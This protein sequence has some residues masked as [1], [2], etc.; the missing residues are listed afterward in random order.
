MAGRL[1]LCPYHPLH[2]RQSI[3]DLGEPLHRTAHTPPAGTPFRPHTDVRQTSAPLLP[4]VAVTLTV[5]GF[6]LMGEK[7]REMQNPGWFP[8]RPSNGSLFA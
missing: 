4:A 3:P 1:A 6:S 2:K 7:L 8:F 5:V